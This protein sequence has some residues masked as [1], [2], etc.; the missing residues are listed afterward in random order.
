[1][2]LHPLSVIGPWVEAEEGR[3]SLAVLH[4][5]PLFWGECLQVDCP[6]VSS[7]DGTTKI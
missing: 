5:S 1:M 4:P 6:L 3:T 2:S 7:W